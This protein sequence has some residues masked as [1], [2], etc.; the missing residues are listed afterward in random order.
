MDTKEVV[1]TDRLLRVREVAVILNM[2]EPTIR[3][4]IF[5]KRIAYLK[6]GKSVRIPTSVIQ[7]IMESRRVN[8]GR[9]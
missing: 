8:P 6:I 2:K 4:W 3:K 7:G 1:A 5:D 9:V